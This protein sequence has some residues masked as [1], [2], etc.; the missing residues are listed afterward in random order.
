MEKEKEINYFGE[1]TKIK[2]HFFK[3]LN[4][5][6]SIVKDKRNQ[7][8]VTY[9][10][11]IILFTVIMKNVSGIVSMNKM[12]KD[13]NNNAVIE[14]IASSLGY[15]SLEEIPHYDK[16]NNFLKSLEISELQKIRDY[17]I[18]ELLKKDA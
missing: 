2:K 16:I 18:R 17:M 10:P 13:F 8:Y 6:L 7:S 15:D 5:K 9:A 1:F 14:N 12:T 3:D 11:E 4:K